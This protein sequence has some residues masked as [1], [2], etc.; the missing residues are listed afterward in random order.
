MDDDKDDSPVESQISL[1]TRVMCGIL[2]FGLWLCATSIY[3]LTEV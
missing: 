1:W 2:L 3:L